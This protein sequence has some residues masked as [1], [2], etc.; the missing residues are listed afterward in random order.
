[1]RQGSGRREV[2]STKIVGGKMP[3]LSLSLFG[4]F[5][6]TLDGEPVTAFGSDKVRALLAFL[7]VESARPHRRAELAGMFWPDLPEKNA[8]HNLSQTLLRLRHALRESKPAT[9]SARQPFLLIT[10]QDFQFNSRSDHHLDVAL[11]TE[12]LRASRQHHHADAQICSVCVQWLHQAAD[13]YHGDL[14]AGFFLR[15]SVGFEEWQLVQQEVLHRQAVE[16]L[17]RL[18]AYHQGR[19][20]HDLVQRYAGQLVALEPW[21]EQGQLQ[22]MQALARG[23]RAAAALEKYTVYCR[24]LAE[25]FNLDPSAEATALFEQIQS[26]QVGAEVTGGPS[27]GRVSAGSVSAAS[28]GDRRQVTALICS[29]RDPAGHSD[30]EELHERLTRCGPRCQAILDRYGGHRQYRHGDECLI[31]FGYPQ[32]HEEATRRAVHA[33]LA[34]TAAAQ[35]TD[36]VRIGIHTGT[37]VV[38]DGHGPGSEACGPIGN[39]S[40]VARGCREMAEP[41]AVLITADTERLVQGWFRCQELGLRALPG[42]AHP[43]EVF[44]VLGESGMRNR[45]AWLKK[46]QTLTSFVGREIELDRLLALGDQARDGNGQAVLISGEPGIGK[47]RLLWEFR[48]RSVWAHQNDARIWLESCCSPLF[49]NTSLYPIIDLLEQILGFEAGD[50]L[51]AKRDRLDRTLAGCDLTQP[52]AKWLLSLL[53]GLPT[54]APAPQTITADLRERMREVFVRLLQRL[55]ARRPLVLVIEDLHWSDPTTVDWLGRSFD[56]LAAGPCLVLLTCRPTFVSPW[57][58]RPYLLSLTLGLLDPAEAESLVSN[59]A[60]DRVLPDE[61]R[62][63]IVRQGDGVPLF[64]EEL[65]RNVL[66]R[67][68]SESSDPPE[69]LQIPRTLR[70]S[71]MARL[72]YAGPAKETAHW[73]AVLGREFAYPVLRAVVPFDE[74]RL[75]NHL[76][77]LVETDLVKVL[78]RSPQVSFA[79]KH[80]LI[81]EAAYDSLLRQT[82][83][84]YHRRIA[85]TLEM[86]FPQVAQTQPELLAQHY[87]SAGGHAQA[88]DYWLRAGERATAQAATLEAKTFFNLA[89]ERIEPGDNERRWRA[90]LGR[91]HVLSMREER[92][93]QKEDIAALLD[94]AEAFGD[95]ERRARA[96]DRQVVYAL[97]VKEFRLM[98][99]ASEAAIATASRAGHHARVVDVMA[100]KATALTYL[101]EWSAARQA[102]EETLAKLPEIEDEVVRNYALGDLAFYYSR[103]GD[104]SRALL[105]M[106]RGAE[107]AQRAQHRSKH[108]RYAL[109]IGFV[110]AQ[111]GRYAEARAALEEGLALAEAIDDRALQTSLRYNLSYVLWCSGNRRLAQALG[112]RA[113]Q[114][115]RTAGSNSVG[116]ACCLVYLGTFADEAG[117]LSAAAAYLAEARDRYLRI[118][119]APLRMEGQAVEARCILALGRRE[120]ARQLATEVWAHLRERGSEGMD[121]PSR[122]YICIADVLA[123]VGAPGIS[124]Q[125]VIESGYRDLMQRAEKLSDEAWRQSFLENVAENREI[126]ERWKKMQVEHAGLGD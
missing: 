69:A 36:S 89:I 112:E 90:L 82:R 5:E 37:V 101:G 42:L 45:L 122:V 38:S 108:G 116:L 40:G 31:Y 114:E 68:T 70:D 111:L 86:H 15:G 107:A 46:S 2:R 126:I 74:Q 58:P 81:Q 6:A 80:T 85:E 115:F 44:Q 88:V 1:M 117:N 18:A 119:V 14:L 76:A 104:L 51:E 96:Y 99:Q 30:P 124:S 47:S 39:V 120:Q 12:L 49:Q 98:L 87:F 11:F 60:G 25:E 53:L 21:H 24:I 118:G 102:V 34:M 109:N 54:D 55:A 77:V 67:Q 83:K 28:Q 103:T 27:P 71:L 50:S 41:G 79:F 4:T 106:R 17:A 66:D 97:R 35:D 32:A 78:D 125:E 7:A 61:I 91:E 59:V 20:E 3:H 64:V 19:G 93:A 94:L 52:T 43:S 8:A 92:E 110:S 33:G 23:G 26:G 48:S 16:M 13:L 121:F 57:L 123:A 56:A 113:L 105:L 84:D 9:D 62:Q 75:Q 29:Q 22:L 63:R 95:D 10:P 100:A 72:D 65:T 73:A